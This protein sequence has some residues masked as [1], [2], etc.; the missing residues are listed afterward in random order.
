[1][2]RFLVVLALLAFGALVLG[3]CVTVAPYER[4]YLASP[5]MNAE[6]EEG[7]SSFQ[8]HVFDSREGSSGGV[9]STGGGCG[10]N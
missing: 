3:G 2:R 5:A 7:E 9:G 4:E 1:M 8:A 6:M 10:C